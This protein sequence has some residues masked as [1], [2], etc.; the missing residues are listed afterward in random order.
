MIIGLNG[1]HPDI[2][3]SCRDASPLPWVG[4]W[5]RELNSDYFVDLLLQQ[6]AIG[7]ELQICCIALNAAVSHFSRC[8]GSVSLIL[9]SI[10]SL[11]AG[12]C[13]APLSCVVTASAIHLPS[14]DWIQFEYRKAAAVTARRQRLGRRSR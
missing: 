5:R 14:G 3:R 4:Q 6:T 9:A 1:F 11:V 10:L 8:W 13:P 12:G 7:R 2:S